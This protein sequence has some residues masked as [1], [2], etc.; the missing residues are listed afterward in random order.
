MFVGIHSSQVFAALLG[1][2][3]TSQMTQLSL[4]KT[5]GIP[6]E[7]P[8]LFFIWLPHCVLPALHLFSLS[9]SFALLVLELPLPA[10]SC[11]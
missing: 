7:G 4:R 5:L 8:R 3:W 11:P 6:D 10:P 9:P 1:T 2:Y